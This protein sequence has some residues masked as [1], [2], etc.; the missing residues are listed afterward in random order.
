MIN[1]SGLNNITNEEYLAKLSVIGNFDAE[2][3]NT[4][5]ELNKYNIYCKYEDVTLTI[6]H[7]R[8]MS[9]PANNPSLYLP[10][11]FKRFKVKLY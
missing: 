7:I 2:E 5:Y 3:L 8:F 11:I 6:N 10:F 4:L 9:Y 1:F